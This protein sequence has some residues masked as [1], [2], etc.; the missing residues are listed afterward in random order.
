MFWIGDSSWGWRYNLKKL[1]NELVSGL[2]DNVPICCIVMYLSCILFSLITKKDKVIFESI[3]R[4]YNDFLK[5]DY[6]RCSICKAR[7]KINKIRWIE[8]YEKHS[9]KG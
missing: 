7:K 3:Y 5:T 1:P 6:W 4:D 2:K 9:P 8:N